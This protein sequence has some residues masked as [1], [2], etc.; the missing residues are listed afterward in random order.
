MNRLRV[1]LFSSFC[2]LVS[3]FAAAPRPNVLL[4]ISDD[5]GFGDFG[6]NGN[7]LVHTPN[8]DRHASESAVYRNFIVTAACSPTRSFAH[9]RVGRAAARE[10]ARR[11]D[12][13]ACVLQSR[14]L[15]HNACRQ[16]R[17]REDG[18]AIARRLRLDDWM[19]GAGYEH[20]AIPRSKTI[21]CHRR[22]PG[23]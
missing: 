11:R 1:L 5:Q 9:G 8:L 21:P 16:A 15:S 2:I 7:K 22:S 13:D 19:G 3:S 14:W 12:K 23:R 17:L 4:I 10:L 6:F 20:K 18:Q